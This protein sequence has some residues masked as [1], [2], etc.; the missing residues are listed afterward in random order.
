[1]LASILAIL[2]AP[3]ATPTTI[4]A[5][6]QPVPLAESEYASYTR[7]VAGEPDDKLTAFA[8]VCDCDPNRVVDEVAEKVG[9]L[10]GVHIHRSI[11]TACGQ[12]AQHLVVTGLANGTAQ[13]V[14]LYAFRSANKLVLISYDFSKAQASADDENDLLTLC[15]P[16]SPDAPGASPSPA[17]A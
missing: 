17:G 3:S 8:R 11:V 2:V 7:P 1:M 15:S 13:N 16:P 10:P 14:D 9:T 5:S 12:T 6:W 4:S